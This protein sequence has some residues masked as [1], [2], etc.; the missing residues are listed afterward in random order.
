MNAACVHDEVEVVFRRVDG[1][2]IG[3]PGE[4]VC[5]DLIGV[6]NV[7]ILGGKTLDYSLVEEQVL[8]VLILECDLRAVG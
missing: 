5:E 4:D 1:H 3:Q 8:L 7:E 6:V 2:L